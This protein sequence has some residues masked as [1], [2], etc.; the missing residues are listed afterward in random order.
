[1]TLYSPVWHQ[2]DILS[3]GWHLESKHPVLPLAKSTPPTN[4]YAN[5]RSIG[6]RWRCKGHQRIRQYSV[7]L[8]TAASMNN[9]MNFHHWQHHQSALSVSWRGF[10]PLEWRRGKIC[11]RITWPRWLLWSP[12]WQSR[13][14]HPQKESIQFSPFPPL[15]TKASSTLASTGSETRSAFCS[16]TRIYTHR[17][18]SEHTRLRFSGLVLFIFSVSSLP[19]HVIKHGRTN[20]H[21]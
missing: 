21:L 1:M 13:K 8:W 7:D 18:I 12:P 11:L 2:C 10:V 5:S 6:L 4:L 17:L 14:F 16:S 19:S 15:L 9:W 20:S 3:R